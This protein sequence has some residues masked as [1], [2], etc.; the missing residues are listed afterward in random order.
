MQALSREQRLSLE[1]AQ[2]EY[3]SH[4]E[5]AEELLAVRGIDLEAAR[6]AGLGVVRN[7]IPQHRH[8][9]GRLSIPYITR[10]GVVNFT[11]RRLGEGN[12]PKYMKAE[13][14]EANLYGVESLKKADD[15]IAICE[16]ELD[17]LTLHIC[18][19][20]ALGIPGAKNWKPH[21][22]RIFADFSRVYVFADGDT[23]GNELKDRALHQL[24]TSGVHVK[25][26]EGEDVN[27]LYVQYGPQ[28][29]W[30]GIK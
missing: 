30:S 26:P 27:S 29:L 23:A 3:S 9:T 10:A 6:S 19:I 7:P 8:L 2:K 25:M 1:Q 18:G 20:P 24:G 16:G 22:N 13:G 21:W 15:W 17:A 5:E 14:F 4:V 11:F 12:S 28:V